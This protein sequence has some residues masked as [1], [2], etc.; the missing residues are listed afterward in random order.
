[1]VVRQQDLPPGIRADQVLTGVW[2]GLSSTLDQDTQDL[3][4]QHR[5]MLRRGVE[6]SA[7]D[8]LELEDSIRLRLGSYADTSEERLA[9]E[10]A[11]RFMAERSIERRE[12]DDSERLEMQ[13]EILEA[14]RAAE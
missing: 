10:T 3:L 13:N 11:A 7:P 4:D 12:L 5:Q 8:R 9:Q 1:M 14:L 2:F 6:R